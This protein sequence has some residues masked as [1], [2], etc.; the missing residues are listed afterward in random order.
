MRF[1]EAVGQRLACVRLIPRV[2]QSLDGFTV[3]EVRVGD[4]DEW[5]DGRSK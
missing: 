2:R 4:L 3:T 5:A 1:L